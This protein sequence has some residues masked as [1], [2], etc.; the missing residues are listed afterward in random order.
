MSQEAIITMAMPETLIQCVTAQIA[1]FH[2]K[3]QRYSASREEPRVQ[4]IDLRKDLDI[5]KMPYH[6]QMCFEAI[7][8]Y[9]LQEAQCTVQAFRAKKETNQIVLAVSVKFIDKLFQGLDQSV[10]EPG[11]LYL[12]NPCSTNL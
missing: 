9:D 1:S 7:H 10:P 3:L 6:K 12:T 4:K 11:V 5:C 8:F 2:C